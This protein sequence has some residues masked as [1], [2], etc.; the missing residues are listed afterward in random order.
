MTPDYASPEQ[1][2]GERVTTASDVYALGVVLYELLAGRKPYRLTGEPGQWARIVCERDPERPS[3]VARSREL[4]GDLDAIVQKAMR[5]EPERRYASA[6]QLAED[7]VRWWSGEPVRA[8]RGTLAYRAVKFVRR[9]RLALAAAG[10]A[11]L[12]LAGGVVATVREARRARRA[13]VIAERRFNEVRALANSFLFELHD[14]IRDLP[15]STK[16]RALLVRRGLEYLDRLSRESAGDRALRRELAEAYM[17]VGD[18][19]GNP[20]MANLGDIPGALGSYGKAIALLEPPLAAGDAN[21]AEQSALATAY[22]VGGGIRLVAGDPRAAVA[23]AEKGLPLRKELAA[24]EPANEHRRMEL[25]QAWQYYA[26]FL[27]GAGRGNE[28][29]EALRQQAVLLRERLAAAPADRQA[30]RS[31]GQNLYL[32][33][34][35]L[36]V[37]GDAPGALANYRKAAEIQESLREEEPASTQYRRDLGYLRTG[38]GGLY[39]E[40]GKLPEADEQFRMA[41]SHFES[42]ASADPRSV[43]GR[44]GVALSRHNLGTVER[45][46]GRLDA[47]VRDFEA[48]RHIYEPIVEGDP[49]NAWAAGMLADCYLELAEAQAARPAR[50]EACRTYRLADARYSALQAAGR[51][52]DR[53]EDNAARARRAVEACMSLKPSPP[54]GGRGGE[55]GD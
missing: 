26:F 4:R 12:A 19:Q 43:D 5:K 10:F 45:R 8:R 2:R 18:V 14:E 53:K 35:S 38:L 48:A 33:G 44:L 3:A 32:S 28:G 6:E 52:I 11:A 17:R 47:A 36:R 23:M 37:A 34:E 22:L 55:G 27:Q 16:A 42:I 41:L 39:L 9:H 30:R 29:R 13:E 54:G 24:R 40:T 20:Y 15:G 25:G 31:L 46:T 49:Q 7:L 50:D 1:I 51:L 21:D